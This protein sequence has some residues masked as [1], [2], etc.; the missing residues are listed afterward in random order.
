MPERSKRFN[1]NY[2]PTRE[3]HGRLVDNYEF[4]NSTKW[5]K[6]S[7]AYRNANPTCASCEKQG[8]VGPADI[9]DHRTTLRELQ[10]TGGNPYAWENL[11]S[12]CHRCHNSKSGKESKGKKI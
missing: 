10:E 3:V 5:R 2:I 4:Y 7:R 11:Q 6:V 12:L 1:P 8:R 9:C